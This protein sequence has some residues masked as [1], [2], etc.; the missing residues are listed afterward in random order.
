MPENSV[1]RRCF[2]D[3]DPLMEAYHDSE[4]GVPVHDDARLFEALTLQTFQA[5]LS[6]RTILYKREG[7]RRAFQG[8][9]PETVARFD[10]AKRARLLTDAAIVRN[11]KK[12]GAA[13]A[14]ARSTLQVQEEWGS[15]DHYLW[16][17][18]GGRT[19]RSP[20]RRSWDEVAAFTPESETM[21]QDLRSRGFRFVGPTVCYALMQAVGMVDD[22]LAWCFRRA[23][24]PGDV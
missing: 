12:I 23:G 14:N 10:G 6:W 16:D 22:H 4:W 24:S 18:T 21:A 1:I 3:G 17:F 20:D 7:F 2:G 8:F 19:L 5:G 13:V 9:S 15:L 11:R